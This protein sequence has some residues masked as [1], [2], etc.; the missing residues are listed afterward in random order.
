MRLPGDHWIGQLSREQLGALRLSSAWVT[1]ERDVHAGVPLVR[2]GI[3]CMGQTAH[4]IGP[5]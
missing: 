1:D 4:K 5:A 3:H 2:S